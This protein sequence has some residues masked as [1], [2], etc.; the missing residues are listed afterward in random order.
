[1]TNF[2]KLHYYFKDFESPE[3][4]ITSGALAA[5]SCCL[6][7]KVF[8]QKGAPVFAN[9]QTVIVGPP[10]IGKTLPMSFLMN[11]LRTFYKNSEEGN[12]SKLK[13][14]PEIYVA[15]DCTT[16]EEVY[17]F[18]ERAGTAIPKDV[19]KDKPY[20]HA[21][22][23]FLLEDELG[24]LFKPGPNASNLTLFLNAGYD[25]KQTFQYKT[26]RSGENNARNLCI[27]FF[28]CTTPDWME[29]NMDSQVIGNG[30]SSRVL[31]VYGGQCRQLTTFLE[32]NDLQNKAFKE[33][34]EHLR[35]LT[36]LY[37]E[38][39]MTP[40][41]REFYDRWYQSNPKTENRINKDQVLDN[42][43][44]RV[45]LHTLKLAM[46]FHFLES[47]DLTL[48]VD[49]FQ[50]AIRFR[51]LIE[52]DMHK[53]LASINQNP[54][55]PL[56]EAMLR[57]IGSKEDGVTT[58]ELIGEM[59]AKSRNGLEGIEQAKEFLRLTEKIKPDGNR[60]VLNKKILSFE[61]A[62][63]D[64]KRDNSNLRNAQP[65]TTLVEGKVYGK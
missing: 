11:E 24:I 10:G 1:M 33:V 25:C 49:D 23:T 32:F 16:L 61:K 29:K 19:T 50:K 26:K 63:E 52:P 34:V 28:G 7:R 62:Q 51:A 2:E 35:S 45:R 42:Y 54:L 30:W 48:T 47:K 8:F 31:F 38:V 53:A 20:F 44:S 58:A 6:G 56:S 27:N 22:I 14:E 3:H 21:S 17:Q 41:C 43:Y 64:L 15:P 57:Y 37:G 18:I 60:W 40:E 13:L 39:V 4:F 65:T 55:V 46:A 59:F 9:Q 12:G 5:V 36:K